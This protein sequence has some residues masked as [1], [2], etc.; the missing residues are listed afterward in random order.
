MSSIRENSLAHHRKLIPCLAFAFCLLFAACGSQRAMPGEPSTGPSS[1][2]PAPTPS[3]TAVAFLYV[4]SALKNGSTHQIDA[5]AA[6]ADG[7]LTPV[8]GSPFGE[9]VTAMAVAANTLFAES[10]NGF[11]LNSYAIQSDG[12]LQFEA[13][14][15]TSQPG[16]CNTL[17]PLFVDH[18]G[19]SLY[20]LE[21]RGSGCANNTYESFAVKGSTGDLTDL[22]N[23]SANNWLTVPATFLA[24]NSYAY[25]ATCVS[26][27]YGA[28]YGFRRGAN[29]LLTQITINAANPAP[30]AGSFYC[31][32]L[33]AADG[34]DHVAIAMQPIDQ[35][36]FS[37]GRPAQLATYT[38]ASD[39]S[40]TT[41]S[42]EQNIPNAPV[43]SVTDLKMSP[44]GTLLAVAGSGGL[45][46]FH[47][48][49]AGPITADTGLL[50]S[51]AIDQCFWDGQ[52]HLYAISHT[53]GKLYVFTVTDTS[54]SQAQGSPY[55]IDNPQ[56]L[57]VQPVQ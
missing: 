43:G 46:V 13:T 41:A 52:N 32:T 40:L 10:S 57:A 55:P 49:G 42:T 33:A 37:A 23:S 26:G 11:D 6:S 47:F 5:F 2:G 21:F 38:A 36:T 8:S 44:S 34:A 28:I 15:N 24:N 1:P 50:A 3:P 39:G 16:N 22:G 45:A 54:A 4:S 19:A 7:A 9:D 48:N 27:M 18:S 20:A 17:G 25:T 12:S 51:D 56:A 30:P 14:T 53:A 35:Q 29:G 31:P